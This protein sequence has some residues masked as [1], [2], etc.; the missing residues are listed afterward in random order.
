M[1]FV[2]LG[3]PGVDNRAVGPLAGEACEE[4]VGVDDGAEHDTT[5]APLAVS[6]F[7][8]SSSVVG[9]RGARRVGERRQ[10]RRE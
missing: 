3:D 7:L 9:E 6:R 5:I 10:A 4:D 1:G 2:G 8:V